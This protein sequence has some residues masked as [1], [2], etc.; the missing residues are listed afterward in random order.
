L[1]QSVALV[2][3]P[4]LLFLMVMTAGGLAIQGGITLTTDPLKPKLER[5][6]LKA[7]V[8]RL[9]SAQSAVDTAKALFRLIVLTVLVI[10]IVTGQ[11]SRYV[12]GTN[13]SLGQ[14]AVSGAPG[15]SGRFGRRSGRLRLPAPQDRQAAEDDQGR[16]QER[17]P[18]HRR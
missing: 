13:R 10:Q 6:S 12:G 5:I 11:V 17:E 7:G 16:G 18:Q 15:R 8:K 9:F 4:F 1:I 2:F 3:L 14:P